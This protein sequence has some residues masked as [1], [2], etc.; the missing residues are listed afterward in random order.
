MNRDNKTTC[1]LTIHLPQ[2]PSEPNTSQT[3]PTECAPPNR[4]S[5]IKPA[6]PSQ[7][8]PTKPTPQSYQRKHL[9]KRLQKETKT[10]FKSTLT[11]II[12]L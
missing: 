8:T 11:V 1:K 4:T 7:T 5:P 2:E 12:S 3:T 10:Y 6:P 9:K